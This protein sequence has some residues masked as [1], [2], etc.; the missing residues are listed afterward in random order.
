MKRLNVYPRDVIVSIYK[1]K[2]TC[3]W[4]WWDYVKVKCQVFLTTYCGIIIVGEGPMYVAFVGNPC[5]SPQPVSTNL[6][7]SLF[8]IYLI[9]QIY[10]D[11]TTNEITSPGT[12]EIF[13][14]P[15]SLT[16]TNNNDSTVPCIWSISFQKS[17]LM[18]I[19]LNSSTRFTWFQWTEMT[20]RTRNVMLLL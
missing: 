4:L 13:G 3:F 15:R 17:Y 20:S 9:Y 18:I 19:N 12:K 11:C 16:P 1:A 5:P 14:Y 8:N 6:Y 10:P 7:T 2:N